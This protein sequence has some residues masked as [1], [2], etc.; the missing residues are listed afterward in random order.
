MRILS[1]IAVVLFV[2]ALAA[3]AWAG[4]KE[5]CEQERDWNLKISGCTGAI[6]SGQWQGKDLA[7]AYNNRGLAYINLGEHRRGIENY[8][9]AL[10]LDPGYALAYYNRG[11][12]YYGLGEYRRAIED[13]DEAL[14]LDPGFALAYHNRG[15]AYDGLGDNAR[16][17]EDYDLSL[18]HI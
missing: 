1:L 3:P 7:S 2:P 10:R 18:I 16:A 15:Y 13:F 6:D 11:T 8:N 5:N 9:E 12:F 17:I 14:R 4:M